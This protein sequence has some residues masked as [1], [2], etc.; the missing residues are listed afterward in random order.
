MD[1]S[2]VVHGGEDD[3][4]LGTGDAE[5]GSLASGN[6]GRESAAVRLFNSTEPTS[7]QAPDVITMHQD[8]QV[9]GMN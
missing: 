8:K 2:I 9:D 6:A 3:L 1:R 4:G 5:A 7:Q